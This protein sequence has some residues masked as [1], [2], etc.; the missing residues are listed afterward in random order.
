MAEGKCYFKIPDP[1]ENREQ[2]TC[3]LHNTGNSK[4][5][6]KNFVAANHC[7]VCS[8]HFHPMCFKRDLK[9]ELC[10]LYDQKRA[11]N[12]VEGAIPTNNIQASNKRTN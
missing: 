1:K 2:C 8:D 6:I 9:S 11:K 4:H 10:P 3:W 5:D 7:V 12:L